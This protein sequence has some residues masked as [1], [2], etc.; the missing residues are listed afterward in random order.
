MTRRVL[1]LA[2]ITSLAVPCVALANES[3]LTRNR[4]LQELANRNIPFK[5]REMVSLCDENEFH[6]WCEGFFSA[7]IAA[8]EDDG[9]PICVPRQENGR[10]AFDGVW[11]VVKSWLYRRQPTYEVTFFD[12]VKM[13]LTDEGACTDEA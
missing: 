9:V 6:E 7:T 2:V 3:G 4:A 10:Y 1:L 5:A 12:A 13:S 8:I 11:T